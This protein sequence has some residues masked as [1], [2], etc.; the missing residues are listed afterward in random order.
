MSNTTM[1]ILIA[2]ALAFTIGIWMFA[3]SQR[4][5]R[6]RDKFG[7][8]YDRMVDETGGKTGKAEAILDERQKRVSKLNIQPLGPEVRNRFAAEWREVQ[9]RFVDEPKMAVWRADALVHRALKERGYPMADFEE[10]AAHIS[11]QYPDV[12]QNYRSAHEIALREQQGRATTEEL[13]RAMQH[14]RNL[15][16]HVLETHVTQFEEVHR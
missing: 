12:V 4:T 11:V 15:F 5:R 6:L 9:A 2:V 10:Q 8:E 13:R 16:E 1:I 3:R 14:Y 7:P